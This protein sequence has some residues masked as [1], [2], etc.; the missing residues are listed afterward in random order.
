MF[1]VG[2]LRDVQQHYGF[3]GILT[4]WA[5]LSCPCHSWTMANWLT[6]MPPSLYGL[7]SPLLK[8]LALAHITRNSSSSLIFSAF[9]FCHCKIFLEYSWP[10]ISTII[11]TPPYFNPEML[12]TGQ[13]HFFCF[14]CTKVLSA[15]EGP[16]LHVSLRALSQELPEKGNLPW[17]LGLSFNTYS[18][19]FCAFWNK[20][21]PYITHAGFSLR[22]LCQPSKRDIASTIP[23]SLYLYT[24][25]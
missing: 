4:S 2:L 21:S 8:L 9:S 17:F 20:V 13:W 22:T 14:D 6:E 7:L 10:R 3:T 16:P 15:V 19:F 12:S 23:P 24:F 25:W 5:G 11:S 1:L 18:L